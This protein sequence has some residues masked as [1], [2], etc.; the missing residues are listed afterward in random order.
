MTGR[1]LGRDPAL[2]DF[3]GRPSAA[4]GRRIWETEGALGCA[5]WAGIDDVF[6]KNGVLQGAR[7]GIVDAEAEKP[8]YWHIRRD[9]LPQ[10]ID[11][12]PRACGRGLRY[13]SIT[14]STIPI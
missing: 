11:E 6:I 13:P 1:H 8:E 12:E 5:V 9:I 4:S 14:V 7:G 3:W 10:V 2:R